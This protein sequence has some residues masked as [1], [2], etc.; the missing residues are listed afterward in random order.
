MFNNIVGII[1]PQGCLNV[2]SAFQHVWSAQVRFQFRMDMILLN[3][4]NNCKHN[5][6][7]W[8]PIQIFQDLFANQKV[9]SL[10]SEAATTCISLFRRGHESP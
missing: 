6:W 3:F 9:L 5:I 4:R 7:G 2:I 1:Q 10:G 8:L